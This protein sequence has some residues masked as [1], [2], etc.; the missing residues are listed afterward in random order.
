MKRIEVIS[1]KPSKTEFLAKIAIF[2]HFLAKKSLRATLEN[3]LFLVPDRPKIRAFCKKIKKIIAIFFFLF[4]RPTDFF[5]KIFSGKGF[6]SYMTPSGPPI[7]TRIFMFLG[8]KLFLLLIWIFGLYLFIAK[9]VRTNHF[10][11]YVRRIFQ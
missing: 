7:C 3:S 1:K 5:Q 9:E 11:P 6:F 8:L 4:H 10:S 2:W